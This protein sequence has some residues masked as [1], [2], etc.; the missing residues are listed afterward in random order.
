LP[1]VTHRSHVQAFA[2]SLALATVSLSGGPALADVDACIE[3]AERGQ[4]QRDGGQL[5]SARKDFIACAR[6]ACPQIIRLDCS[7]W[8]ADID[9]Q[10]PSIVP[11][12]RDG[13]GRDVTA[14]GLSIDGE[15][16]VDRAPGR[17]LPLDPGKHRLVWTLPG[18]E[19]VVQ[20]IV[21]RVAEQNRLVDATFAGDAKKP[22][23]PAGPLAPPPHSTSVSVWT[24]PLAGVA[25]AGFVGLGIMGSMATNRHDQLLEAC[26]PNCS[27]DEVADVRGLVIGA[28]V[29]LAVGVLATGGALW[30]A[31]RPAPGIDE[32]AA[33]N[34]S[35]F[36]LVPVCGSGV[37]PYGAQF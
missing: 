30:L 34:K 7:K 9:K 36:M 24:W 31:L 13:Q 11:R 18:H 5:L 15:P 25:V 21:V 3:N 2:L 22:P 16:V 20:D 19:A 1:E 37:A 14:F 26:A 4:V 28:N 6:G 10:I 35:T 29:S 23:G 17:S 32:G 27:D 33:E 12:A 8:L